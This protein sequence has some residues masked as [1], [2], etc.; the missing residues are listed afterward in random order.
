MLETLELTKTYPGGVRALENCSLSIPSGETFGLLGP[1]GAGKTTLLRILLGFLRPTSGTARVDGFDCW[2]QSVEVRRRIAYLPGDVR[3]F[4]RMT[5]REFLQYLAGLRGNPH[6]RGGVVWAERLEL[7]LGR[8]VANMSTGM[9][10]KLAIA[11]TFAAAAPVMILDEPTS[12]LDPNVRRELGRMIDEAH[13]AGQTIVLSSHVLAEVEP[14]CQRVGIMKSGRL[15]HVETMRNLRRSHR[16]EGRLTGPWRD[17]PS[18]LE[19]R[20]EFTPPDRQ[21]VV[22]RTEAPLMHVLGWLATLPLEE[23]RIEPIGLRGIYDRFHLDATDRPD[24]APPEPL[25]VA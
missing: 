3:L 2:A 6:D 24:A 15:V 13:S 4:R 16:I 9:R 23:V 18:E 7:D 21:G 14:L 12:S 22:M 25:H 5:A 8:R 19:C 17:P 20:W 1:N 10:Q 11:A